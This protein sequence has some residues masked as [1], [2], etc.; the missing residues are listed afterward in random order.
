MR[1]QLSLIADTP[2]AIL[3]FMQIHSPARVCIS[4]GVLSSAVFVAVDVIT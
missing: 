4:R 3:S 1:T 2:C